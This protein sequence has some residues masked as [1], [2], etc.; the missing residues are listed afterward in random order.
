MLECDDGNLISK[1]GCSSTCKAEKGWNCSTPNGLCRYTVSPRLRTV[2]ISKQLSFSIVFTHPIRIQSS[3]EFDSVDLKNLI[4]FRVILN[5]TTNQ[6]E[7][8]N[9]ITILSANESNYSKIIEG[10]L[11]FPKSLYPG[12]VYG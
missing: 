8:V 12:M 10:Y 6:S 9:N 3:N 2:K 1:D 11:D 5:Q 4:I 7:I